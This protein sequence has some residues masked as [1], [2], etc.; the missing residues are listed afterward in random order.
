MKKN[1][2][3]YSG[4]FFQHAGIACCPTYRD[5]YRQVTAQLLGR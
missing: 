3:I 5:L 2:F 4:Y 1:R